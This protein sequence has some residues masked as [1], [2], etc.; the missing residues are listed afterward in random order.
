MIDEKLAD[1]SAVGPSIQERILET[2]QEMEKHLK[3]I[4]YYS[5]PERAFMASAGKATLPTSAPD[6]QEMIK[7]EV[8]K[9]L[10]ENE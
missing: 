2:L 8:G 1:K 7:E 6:L 9:Y 4:V 10:K 5:T 3:A